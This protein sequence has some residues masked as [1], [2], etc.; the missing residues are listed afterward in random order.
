[1][2]INF[3]GFSGHAAANEAWE[4]ERE[5]VPNRKIFYAERYEIPNNVATY[6]RVAALMRSLERVP[7]V[8]RELGADL[9]RLAAE[10]G[11]EDS[12]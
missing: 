10:A 9:E 5:R 4:L 6:R 8:L 3:R 12:M 1:L 7:R 2:R 11:A